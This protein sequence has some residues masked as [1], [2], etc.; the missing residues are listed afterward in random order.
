VVIRLGRGFNEVKGEPDNRVRAGTRCPTC[1]S[2]RPRRR[3]HRGLA[4][5]RGIPGAIGGALRMNGGAYGARPR[6]F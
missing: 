6:T 5:L 3:R 1:A 4:F 2:P